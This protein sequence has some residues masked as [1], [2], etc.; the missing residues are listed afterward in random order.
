MKRSMDIG[1]VDVK[2][3][4]YKPFNEKNITAGSNLDDA[5]FAS[6]SF[7]G[8]F[9]PAE[10]MGS[11]YYDGSAVWDVDIFAAINRC[12]EKGFTE[13][14][15]IVDVILTSAANLKKVEAE[16]YKSV[17]MLFR[18]FQISS[19]YNSMDGLLRAK[20]AYT[21][22]NFRNVFAPSE[23]IPSSIEPMVSNF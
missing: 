6:L 17:Q 1:I 23:N 15:I 13:E 10:V 20:F 16:N 19:F 3:G 2:D 14:N 7:A 21:K 4:S 18:Y 5:L 22:V 8:F 11:A 12:V 9:P